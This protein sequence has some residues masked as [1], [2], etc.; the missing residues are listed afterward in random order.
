VT[1]GRPGRA[2]QRRSARRSCGLTDF[3][4]P[5]VVLENLGQGWLSLQRR[6]KP[7]SSGCSPDANP[8][9]LPAGMRRMDPPRAGRRHGS[10]SA[11]C[12]ATRVTAL[13]LRTVIEA[14]H[15]ALD[16]I[17]PFD[18]HAHTGIDVDGTARTCE[19]RSRQTAP[20]LRNVVDLLAEGMPDTT[21]V[22]LDGGHACIP[23]KLQELRR[24]T[25][26]S[27]RRRRSRALIRDSSA[28][29]R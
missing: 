24:S 19:E 1:A 22:E 7:K 2:R 6:T 28:Q 11:R 9:A 20:W 17:R 12:P 26:E 3:S 23:G 14:E 29:V 27:C 5:A 10:G 15:A 18:V 25:R 4:A 13:S 21:V 16:G 8:S